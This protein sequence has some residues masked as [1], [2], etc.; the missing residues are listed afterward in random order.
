MLKHWDKMDMNIGP[1]VFGRNP[2][3]SP[4]RNAR[5][6]YQS[7][8]ASKLGIDLLVIIESTLGLLWI[9]MVFVTGFALYTIDPAVTVSS[10]WAHSV[11]HLGWWFMIEFVVI[12]IGQRS[13]SFTLQLP[14]SNRLQLSLVRAESWLI[15]HGA[16][17][18]LAMVSDAVHI[19]F[20]GLEIRDHESTFYYD[21]YGWLIGF[22]CAL[23]LQLVFVKLPL[24][25]CIVQYYKRLRSTHQE[26]PKMTEMFQLAPSTAER[27]D[28][29]NTPLLQ[30]QQQRK[31][32]K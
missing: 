6:V 20:T 14:D 16:A 32:A 28:R 5:D 26:V 24:L 10:G 1:P 9:A 22:L 21:S 27:D 11:S 13:T 15:F 29:V 19:V 30:E 7:I 2:Q 4:I 18:V 12:L 23:I 31:R 17:L 25:W 8:T 3:N